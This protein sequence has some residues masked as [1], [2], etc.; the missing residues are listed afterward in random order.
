MT[1]LVRTDTPNGPVYVNMDNVKTL[2]ARKG[3]PGGTVFVFDKD[4][5]LSVLTDIEDVLKEVTRQRT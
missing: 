4:H 3:M 1:M 2:R 5:S